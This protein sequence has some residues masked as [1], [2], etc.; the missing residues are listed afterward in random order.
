[1][2]LENKN[3]K[4]YPKFRHNLWTNY[5]DDTEITY[6]SV[7]HGTFE[8]PTREARRFL[9]IRS[10]CTG[11]NS[12]DDISKKTMSSADEIRIMVDSLAEIDI[13]HLP[14]KPLDSIPK[15]QIRQTLKAAAKI[16]SEQLADTHISRDIFLGKTG[17]NV[18]LG[19][20]L[21][22]YH[23]VKLFPGALEVAA[24]HAKGS[25]RELLVEYARQEKG[26][27]WFIL[28]SLLKAGVTKQEVEESIPLISTRTIDLLFKELFILEPCAVLLVASI[29]EAED[30]N[31]SAVSEVARVLHEV[32][33]FPI[34]M[35]NPFF[36]H[37]KIDSNLGH[38]RLLHDNIKFLDNI[39]INNLH[40]IVNKLHDIKH[41]FDLQK[42]E[43]NDYYGKVGNYFPRQRVDFFAI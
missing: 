28:Q 17:K 8:I 38:N 35:F 4:I 39:N 12:I 22:T 31:S 21:E 15:K 20:L 27:E 34:D 1:M 36:D 42:L 29:I 23:Y 2:E 3:F 25:L 11:Y 18:V 26:H 7:S 24:E 10:F 5:G 43:I 30:F 13:L 32:H 9:N 6:L 41:A 37:V 16:W 40:D 14:F 33:N 19:W